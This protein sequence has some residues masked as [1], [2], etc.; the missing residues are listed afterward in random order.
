ECDP[1]GVENAFRGVTKPAHDFPRVAVTGALQEQAD[2]WTQLPFSRYIT[3]SDIAVGK[4]TPVAFVI[5]DGI[6][7]IRKWGQLL[8]FGNYIGAGKPPCRCACAWKPE[9]I[10]ERDGLD[11]SQ[12]SMGSVRA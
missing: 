8:N 4:I 10:V 11:L 12:R 3:Q 9:P 2:N 1:I 6:A 5:P 7:F